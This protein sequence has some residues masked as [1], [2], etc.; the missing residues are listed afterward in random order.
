MGQVLAFQ[1]SQRPPSRNA[2]PKRSVA[3][4]ADILFFTGVRY[5][6]QADAPAPLP[7]GSRAEPEL[8][9]AT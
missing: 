2:A 9:P 1:T 8:R 7:P 6:R 3:H 4:N 5:E